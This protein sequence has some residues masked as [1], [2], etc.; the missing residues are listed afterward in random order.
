MFRGIFA[1]GASGRGLHVRTARVGA[2]VRRRLRAGR[3]RRGARC[4]IFT[5]GSPARW[6]PPVDC[7]SR[8]VC[9]PFVVRCR[10]TLPLQPTAARDAALKAGIIRDA[11]RR[12]SGSVRRR[13]PEPEGKSKCRQAGCWRWEPY[14][15]CWSLQRHS[16]FYPFGSVIHVSRNACRDGVGRQNERA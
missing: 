6:C 5:T 3:V 1:V 8:F 10:L 13:G 12:L 7:A 14:P 2:F 16:S 4:E 11:P 15:A 9:A